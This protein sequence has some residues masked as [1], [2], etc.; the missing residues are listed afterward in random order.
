MDPTM[1]NHHI[2][3]NN[4]NIHNENDFLLHHTTNMF[5]EEDLGKGEK[6]LFFTKIKFPTLISMY[7]F[8]G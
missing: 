7:N 1:N 3:Q 5:Q 4:F 6:I 2:A 8:K